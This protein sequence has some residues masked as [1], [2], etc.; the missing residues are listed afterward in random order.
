MKHVRALLARS[1][2]TYP[3]RSLKPRKNGFSLIELLVVTTIIVILAAVGMVSFTS[4]GRNARNGKRKADMETV[5]QALVLYRADMS[6][7][8]TGSYTAMVG[9]LS[10]PSN[11]YLSQPTPQDPKYATMQYSY[12]PTANGFCLCA[13]IE[14]TNLGNSTGTNCTFGT[15]NYYCVTQP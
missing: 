6:S 14:G 12:N 4:A 11:S 9:T 7:Y 1:K 5:R 15:G 10:S 13:T 8:P 3:S 2:K